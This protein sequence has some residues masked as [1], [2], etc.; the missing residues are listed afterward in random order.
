MKIGKERG[1]EEKEKKSDG[2]KTGEGG[3]YR[4]K[5]EQKSLSE[6]WTTA[7][8]F[9]GDRDWPTGR[10]GIVRERKKNGTVCVGGP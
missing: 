9:K 10:G 2:G 8:R 3:R 4:E 5:E 7:Q 1:G 6:L